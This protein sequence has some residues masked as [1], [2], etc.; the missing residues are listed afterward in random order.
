LI[1]I[2]WGI[3]DF[4][5]VHGQLSA[6]SAWYSFVPLILQTRTL[7]HQDL[8]ENSLTLRLF[9]IGT[10][11]L[12]FPACIHKNTINQTG[13]EVKREEQRWLRAE[14]KSLPCPLKVKM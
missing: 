11:T 14:F 12:I 5:Q 13:A 10:N 2:P 6:S 8:P 1:G 4:L 3:G 7:R 9:P